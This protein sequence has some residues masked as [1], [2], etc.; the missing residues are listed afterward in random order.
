[1]ATAQRL[2]RLAEKADHFQGTFIAMGSPCELLLE[3]NDQAVAKKLAQL[4]ADE[5][6]RIEDKFSRYLPGNIIQRINSSDGEPIETDE[7]TADLLDF[8]AALTELSDGGFDITSGV[9]REVWKFDGSANLPSADSVNTVLERVGWHRIDWTRPQLTLQ[10]GM[11]IDLGGVGKEYAVDKAA[12]LIRDQTE[13]PCLINFGGD[14][15]AT[16]ISADSRGWQIGIE[17]P[18]ADGR[19]TNK[20]I[21]LRNGGLATSGDARRFLLKNGIRYGHILNPNTGWPVK[22]AP[23]SIT[24]AADTCTQAGMIATLAMLQ[25]KNAE[26][27]LE[28]QGIQYWCYF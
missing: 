5:A 28:Q 16:D 25:G 23:R 12:N 14:I 13:I 21:R 11:Q 17:A 6:W 7:E 1:V 10:P 15:V 8:A 24:V 2:I 26:A 27:F 4:V 22:D 3:S 19:I 18:D 20:V 9:L